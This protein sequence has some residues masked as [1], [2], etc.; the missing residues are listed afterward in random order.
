MNLIMFFFIFVDEGRSRICI[1]WDLL[2]NW[3]NMFIV[4]EI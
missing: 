4:Y 1:E 3:I 2:K